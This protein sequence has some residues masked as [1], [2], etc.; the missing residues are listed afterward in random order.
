[1][2]KKYYIL[3]SNDDGLRSSGIKALYDAV[4]DIA[5]VIIAAPDRERSGAAHSISVVKPVKVKKAV[6]H[7]AHAFAVS[8]T[9]ADCAKIGILNLAVRKPDLVLSGINHGPNMAQFILYSG[10]IGA[11]AEAAMMGIPAIAFSIDSYKPQDFSFA[12]KYIRQV[13]LS[14]LQGKIRMKSHTL[15]NINLP[16]KPE[17]VI[18]G[19]KI[20]PRGLMEY[21]EKYIRKS[22][23]EKNGWYYWHIIG[24]KESRKKDR[25]DADALENGFITVT[26][27]NFDLN[28]RKAIKGLN[29]LHFGKK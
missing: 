4:K 13:A 9:P 27:L 20:L 7:G 14:A 26:P 28:D 11:A 24:K 19:V 10:T 21:E 2:K 5:D 23:S 16:D 18:S 22:G 25:T 15:L 8:G 17:E 1:M 12:V 6:F 29:R 3:I